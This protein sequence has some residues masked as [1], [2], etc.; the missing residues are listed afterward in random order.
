MPDPREVI[1][2]RLDALRLELSQREPAFTAE[3]AF[4]DAIG[5]HKTSWTQI[6][7]FK[8]DLPLTAAC[9]LKDNWGFSLD[10][11][12]YGEQADAARIMAK[13]GRG[14]AMIQPAKPAKRKAG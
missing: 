14:P 9:R 3:G 13:I 5:L 2:G 8:R 6:K 10:W 7:Q 4:A 11:I 12:Y 1:F